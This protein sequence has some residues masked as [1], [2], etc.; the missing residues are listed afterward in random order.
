[1]VAYTSEDFTDGESRYDVI[2]DNVANRSL[3][4]LRRAL[5][6]EGIIVLVTVDKSGKWIGPFLHPIKAKLRNRMPRPLGETGQWL[7]RVVQGWLNYHAIPG[8]L[9]RM[10]QFLDE[11]KKLWLVQL[12]RRS[13][14]HRMPW[15]RFVRIIR[16][17]LPPPK[18]VHP[19]PSVRFHARLKAGAV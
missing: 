16:R 5:A 6:P 1:M 10:T 18:A 3:L 15:S 2:I 13:Q 8:N 7:R 19:F 9:E 12:R 4:D 11:V 14:R 17:Y